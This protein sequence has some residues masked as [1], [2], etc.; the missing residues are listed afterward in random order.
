MKTII[1]RNVPKYYMNE[2]NK[3]KLSEKNGGEFFC[4]SEKKKDII[5]WISFY[6]TNKDSIKFKELYT[7][8]IHFILYKGVLI[9]FKTCILGR[10]YTRKILFDK[11]KKY[12]KPKYN[13]NLI[14]KNVDK[15][16]IKKY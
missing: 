10:R 13:Y 7:S 2:Y 12:N 9:Y 16:I 1:I 3:S 11:L 4:Q 6:H 15:Y 5:M 14:N 8:I